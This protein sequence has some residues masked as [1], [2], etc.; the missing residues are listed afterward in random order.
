MD[1]VVDKSI[2]KHLPAMLRI[3]RELSMQG[4][5]WYIA[6]KVYTLKALHLANY[7]ALHKLITR[8]V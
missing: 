1:K 5:F 6:F 2:I 4:L 8:P 7:M 3:S